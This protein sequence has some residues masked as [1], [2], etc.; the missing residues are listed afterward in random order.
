MNITI[1]YNASA[2]IDMIYYLKIF[3]LLPLI[4]FV[5]ILHEFQKVISYLPLQFEAQEDRELRMIFDGQNEMH[6]TLKELNRKLDEL[7][8]RQEMVLSR[9]SQLTGGNVQVAQV[10]ILLQGYSHPMGFFSSHGIFLVP[11]NFSRP[12]GFFS[13]H[14]IFLVPW[15]FSFQDQQTFLPSLEF[16]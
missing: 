4:L 13:S 6:N 8:G 14:G 7:M 15:D 12:M 1:H 3:I 10:K 2:F 9:V 16:S 5:F 11:W